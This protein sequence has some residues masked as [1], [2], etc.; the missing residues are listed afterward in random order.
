H[1]RAAGSLDR[2]PHSRQCRRIPTVQRH[3]CALLCKQP[4]NGGADAARTSRHQGHLAV[5]DTH[6]YPA[7]FT[8]L[9]YISTSS[10]TVVASV[11]LLSSRT[12]VK[13]GKRMAR[14]LPFRTTSHPAVCTGLKLLSAPLAS[15]TTAGSSHPSG[16][17]PVS[18]R[19]GRTGGSEAPRP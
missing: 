15:K 12:R 4:G 7:F 13:R 11:G 17:M 6:R 8:R 19:N 18:T 14:P 10:F 3:P 9:R 16:P 1:C 2:S 5:Q